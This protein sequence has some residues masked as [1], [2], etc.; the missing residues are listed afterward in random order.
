[1]QSECIFS[2]CFFQ[3]HFG[4]N[5]SDYKD[6]MLQKIGL[7]EPTIEY[8]ES[9]L[10]L[11]YF[12]HPTF[13]E[14]AEDLEFSILRLRYASEMLINR[15]G[16]S[17]GEQE[18]EIRKLGEA[19]MWNYAMF[20]SIA[21]ASR[22]YCIGL[23]YSAYETILAECLMQIGSEHNLKT[24]LDIKHNQNEFSEQHKTILSNIL[25]HRK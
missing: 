3:E 22:A 25:T 2:S 17:V 5:A 24:A 19:A 13:K 15:Y 14:L 7:S 10:F 18:I 23:R 16:Q 20:A 11:W 4:R 9:K 1:M 8:I 21:R 12:L 6:S